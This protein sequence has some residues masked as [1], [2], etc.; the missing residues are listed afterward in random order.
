MFASGEICPYSSVWFTTTP[1][2]L[3]AFHVPLVSLWLS[4]SS[5]TQWSTPVKVHS[6]FSFYALGTMKWILS[7]GYGI[8]LYRTSQISLQ[9][10]TVGM[11]LLR[12]VDPFIS[13][14]G[15]YKGA[16]IHKLIEFLRN[17]EIH[18]PDSSEQVA[19]SMYCG[20]RPYIASASVW[21]RS[22]IQITV[23]CFLQSILALLAFSLFGRRI[24][25]IYIILDPCHVGF[26]FCKGFLPSHALLIIS[27]QICRKRKEVRRRL[28]WGT[29]MPPEFA[30][31]V[32]SQNSWTWTSASSSE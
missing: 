28:N 1:S 32:F 2:I 18:R 20:C 3:S 10:C 8:L 14:N 27:R 4:F 6:A 30:E 26:N 25:H 31:I 15:E 11:F 9:L 22:L 12:M 23:N 19:A 16:L 24:I 5:P 13:L 29:T 7:R 17:G 21:R